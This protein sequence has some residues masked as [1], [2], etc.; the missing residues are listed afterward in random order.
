MK[1]VKKHFSR[2]S[3]DFCFLLGIVANN[4][5][6]ETKTDRKKNKNGLDTANKINTEGRKEEIVKKIQKVNYIIQQVIKNHNN[7]HK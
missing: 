3:V 7:R 6:G 5:S 4:G 2:F 1:N